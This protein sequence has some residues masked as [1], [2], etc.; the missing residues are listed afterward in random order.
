MISCE[1]GNLKHLF[2]IFILSYVFFISIGLASAADQTISKSIKIGQFYDKTIKFHNFKNFPIEFSFEVEGDVASM[3]SLERKTIEIMPNEDGFLKLTLLANRN[4]GTYVG[5]LLITGDIEEVIPIEIKVYQRDIP[6]DALLIELTPFKDK[7]FT[8]KIFKYSVDLSNMMSD[9]TYNL[10]LIHFIKKIDAGDEEK[11]IIDKQDITIINSETRFEEW[12]VPGDFEI[13]EYILGVEANYLNL[14]S[15][16]STVFVVGL[17]FY[18]YRIFGIIPMWLPMILGALFVALYALYKYIKKKQD[19]K[20]RFHAKVEYDE[21]PQ[22]GDRSL[23]IGVIAET[24]KKAYIDMDKLT[25]HTIIAGS[26]GGG[27]SIATQDVVEEALLKNVSV[28]VFD[29]TAQW[30]GMLRKCTDKGFLSIYPKFGFTLKDARAFSGNIRA[31]KNHREVIDIFKYWQNPGEIQILTTNT[32]DP[33]DYDMFVA[34][35]VREIFHSNLQEFRGLR[36]MAVYDEIHRI[37]PK[38]G[39]SGEGFVQIERGCREFRKWGI[40]ILLISQVLADFVGQIKANINTEIQMK[41]RD[42]SDLER[43]KMKYGEAFIHALVKAPVGSGMLQNAAWNR[44]NPY[45]VTFRP[46]LHSVERLTDEEL[47]K[48]NQFNE[49]VDQLDFEFTQL[50][51]EHGQDV[52]DLRLE[53]KLSKDKIKSGNFNMVKIYLDGLTPRVQKMWD[54]V[55]AK[56]KKMQIKLV[57]E[58]DMKADL[59]AA[60]KDSEDAAKKAA[61]EEAAKKAAE[62]EKEEEEKDIDPE[63]AEGN[64]TSMGELKKQA[65]AAIKQKDWN[66]TNELIMEISSTPLAKEHREEKKQI[67]AKLKEDMELAKNPPKKEDKKSDGSAGGASGAATGGAGAAGVARAESS[68]A[69]DVGVAIAAVAGGLED[70]IKEFED[71]EKSLNDAM[72]KGE[73]EKAKEYF[74]KMQEIYNSLPEEAKQKVQDKFDKAQEAAKT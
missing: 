68:A 39:G 28:V 30:S 64:W 45:Y 37:L 74:D 5:N 22:E 26:T 47:D 1:L 46:I 52:F 20:K 73:K 58:A 24:T 65:E 10:T 69:G 3:V 6:V 32:L 72:G 48:Y 61:A 19:A 49:I 57:D 25:V 17:P 38:F 51:K 67:V 4:N 16:T 9:I 59:E 29:P 60:K 27:K 21:I 33:K 50:E 34:N 70:K 44:G 7:V 40:G 15:S 31:I 18:K 2:L 54:K 42:E 56:P 13:G 23:Y 8:G 63:I 62:P 36:Y 66:R 12:D 35:T 14:T 11:L 71:T 41:T 53:L 43:I 55:G